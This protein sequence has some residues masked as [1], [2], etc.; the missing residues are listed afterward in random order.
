MSM[1]EINDLL[2][3]LSLDELR[4][5]LGKVKVLIELTPIDNSPA[6]IVD[7]ETLVLSCICEQLGH[8]A[9][10]YVSKEALRSHRGIAAFREKIPGLMRYLAATS[11]SRTEQRA[12]LRMGI[13]LLYEQLTEM[14][15]PASARLVM[16]HIHRVPSVLN[17]AFPGYARAGLLHWIVNKKREVNQNADT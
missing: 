15:V 11:E 8:V 1:A 3:K 16:A 12:I 6:A 14:N 7:D 13:E 10:E 4:L 5:L 9:A 17:N 2:P